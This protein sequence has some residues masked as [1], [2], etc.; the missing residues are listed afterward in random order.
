LLEKHLHRTVLNHL[1]QDAWRKLDEPHMIDEPNLDQH[2]FCRLKEK[3]VIGEQAE[4]QEFDQD[5]C[6]IAKYSTIQP[7]VLEGKVELLM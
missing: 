1:P 7:L 4:A 2:V 3:M 6:L 5:A